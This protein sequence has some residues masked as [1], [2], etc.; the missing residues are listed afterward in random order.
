M[1]L[2]I[3]AIPVFIALLRVE[4]ALDRSRGTGFR[5]LATLVQPYLMATL[6][7]VLALWTLLLPD[8]KHAIV[9]DS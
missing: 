1:N 6:C 5:R 4:T 8:S 9:S 3:Y 7:G 2:I